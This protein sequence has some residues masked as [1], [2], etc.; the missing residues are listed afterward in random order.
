MAP[1]IN[2][3]YI[4][5]LFNKWGKEPMKY[6]DKNKIYFACVKLKPLNDS[7]PYEYKF[8][9]K[10]DNDYIW[11]KSIKNRRVRVNKDILL[12]IAIFNS[13][14]NEPDTLED[15]NYYIST[16]QEQTQVKVDSTHVTIKTCVNEE[17][18][19]KDEE[20]STLKN[21]ISEMD[22]HLQM[23]KKMFLDLKA[24]STPVSVSPN[25]SLL[26]TPMSDFNL[27]SPPRNSITNKSRGVQLEEIVEEVPTV[28]NK[29]IVKRKSVITEDLF[30]R[31][32]SIAEFKKKAELVEDGIDIDNVAADVNLKDNIPWSIER[33]GTLLKIYQIDIDVLEKEGVT[34]HEN[35]EK[36]MCYTSP[37]DTMEL[38]DKTLSFP[39]KKLHKL[40]KK[41]CNYKK[42]AFMYVT[43][44][45][46]VLIPNQPLMFKLESNSLQLLKF[47]IEENDWIGPGE[48]TTLKTG[49]EK[50]LNY[51]LYCIIK[52]PN[53]TQINFNVL[54]ANSSRRFSPIGD[55]MLCYK[56]STVFQYVERLGKTPK[57][58]DYYDLAIEL[59]FNP[60]LK[61]IDTDQIIL[62]LKE[63]HLKNNCVY[64]L[65][66]ITQAD[67]GDMATLIR[68]NILPSMHRKQ[69][70]YRYL[71]R[72]LN[73]LDMYHIVWYLRYMRHNNN[74][75]FGILLR[76]LGENDADIITF[77]NLISNK[78]PFEDKPSAKLRYDIILDL[79]STFSKE[80]KRRKKIN[81]FVPMLIDS[82]REATDSLKS[83]LFLDLELRKKNGSI[84]NGTKNWTRKFTQKALPVNELITGKLKIAK[85][86]DIESDVYNPLT[87]KEAPEEA[88]ATQK[89][90]PLVKT[91]SNRN[92]TPLS[93]PF[94]FGSKTMSKSSSKSMQMRDLTMLESTTP[95]A[96]PKKRFSFKSLTSQSSPANNSSPKPST[97]VPPA[98]GSR[99]R[100]LLG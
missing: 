53:N 89:P 36:L 90:S 44:L 82:D 31:R 22:G 84:V 48:V 78:D 56:E 65:L 28:V 40:T 97:G 46:K 21:H 95:R 6:D 29:Q 18:K 80:S 8:L 57:E 50:Y 60:H 4:S 77:I 62:Y 38:Y 55:S 68:A 72:A 52:D 43:G 39:N 2:N 15:L 51:E 71:A 12:P 93:T 87:E 16:P 64:H 23:L 32:T 81:K 75:N 9:Y 7:E 91:S 49:E 24:Q 94:M 17:I 59:Q 58:K 70:T 96:K 34:S 42:C 20:I 3:L 14:S 76:E 92:L 79:L 69:P 54:L 25:N 85:I 100:S 37:E 66:M 73:K 86:I 26:N 63:I 35:L 10:K 98:L 45:I 47:K 27:E 61:D 5:G 19:K 30:S 33:L 74:I 41:I 99:R 88:T 67:V 1:G 13:N 11:E 83:K